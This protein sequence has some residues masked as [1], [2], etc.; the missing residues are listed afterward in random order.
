MRNQ[1]RC[2]IRRTRRTNNEGEKQISSLMVRVQPVSDKVYIHAWVVQL[3]GLVTKNHN[4][5][6]KTDV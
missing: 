1:R 6:G 5:L 3:S 2:L 4:T